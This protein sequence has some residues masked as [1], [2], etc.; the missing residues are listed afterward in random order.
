MK[1]QYGSEGQTLTGSHMRSS[2]LLSKYHNV[3]REK[4]SKKMEG[5]IILYFKKMNMKSRT[6]LVCFCFYCLYDT[7]VYDVQEAMFVNVNRRTD[8]ALDRG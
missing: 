4:V 1:V 5:M 3:C 8:M 2:R 6:R 7:N